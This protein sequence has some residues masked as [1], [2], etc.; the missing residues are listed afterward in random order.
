MNRCNRSDT[1]RSATSSRECEHYIEYIREISDA[2]LVQEH[3]NWIWIAEHSV[4]EPWE[5]FEWKRDQCKAEL[6]RRKHEQR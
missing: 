6:E 2:Q 4:P 5:Q 1:A 3:F